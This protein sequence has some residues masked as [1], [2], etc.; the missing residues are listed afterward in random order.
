MDTA[1]YSN[2]NFIIFPS[3]FCHVSI[4]CWLRPSPNPSWELHYGTSKDEVECLLQYVYKAALVRRESRWNNIFQIIIS[5]NCM[6]NS[7]I[8]VHDVKILLHMLCFQEPNKDAFQL[9]A[10]CFSKESHFEVGDESMYDKDDWVVTCH[11]TSS[12]PKHFNDTSVI[13]CHCHQV[14][15]FNMI[16][17]Q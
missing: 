10:L 15:M 17:K 2:Q 9:H 16:G 5:L 4:L 13:D 1:L 6:L 12:G 8:N 3:N 7:P 14:P 11:W